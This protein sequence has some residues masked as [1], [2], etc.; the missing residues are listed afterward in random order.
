M[1]S[2]KALRESGASHIHLAGR[3]R[4]LEEELGRVGITTFIFVGCDTLRV[5]AEA[6]EA[7]RA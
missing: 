7:V 3:P 4:D 2:I 6:L 1:S 5:L